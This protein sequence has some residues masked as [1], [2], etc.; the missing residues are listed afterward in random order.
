MWG[1]ECLRD[2]VVLLQHRV[3]LGRQMHFWEAGFAVA[4]D[5]KTSIEDKTRMN[6]HL[7]CC[8]FSRSRVRA[9]NEFLPVHFVNPRG[10]MTEMTALFVYVNRH[11]KANIN[12]RFGAYARSCGPRYCT[13]CEC[14]YCLL[15]TWGDLKRCCV[16]FLLTPSPLPLFFVLS[17]FFLVLPG[18]EGFKYSLQLWTD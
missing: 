15:N 5:Q 1:G 16:T 10:N 3:F 18:L 11:N 14:A 8:F 6:L 7:F 2:T 17:L 9:E 13:D 4:W 12:L